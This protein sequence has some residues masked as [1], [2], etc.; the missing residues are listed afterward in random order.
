MN[1]GLIGSDV[2]LRLWRKWGERDSHGS[3]GLGVAIDRG[4]VLLSW[5]DSG[6]GLVFPSGLG[7]FGGVWDGVA[8]ANEPKAT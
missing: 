6:V 3:I 1:W 4:S 8:G 7:L 5:V 2:A